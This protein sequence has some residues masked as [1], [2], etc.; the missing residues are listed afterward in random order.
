MPDRSGLSGAPKDDWTTIGGAPR[1]THAFPVVSPAPRRAA[2]LLP[3]ER[4]RADPARPASRSAACRRR[5]A[6]HRFA[7]GH[8]RRLRVALPS[9]P[10][11][12]GGLAG[13]RS[14]TRRR[15]RA[16]WPR[17]GPLSVQRTERLA[18]F[19]GPGRRYAVQ[20]DRSSSAR[21]PLG[22]RHGQLDH[23]R[24]RTGDPDGARG[25]V[26]RSAGPALPAD[27]VRRSADAAALRESRADDRAALDPLPARGLHLRPEPTR[28]G[29]GLRDR[30]GER[31]WG[32]RDPR[33]RGLPRL[34]DGPRPTA[35]RGRVGAQ[36]W[37]PLFA[38]RG[39][40]GHERCRPRS[41]GQRTR[42]RR[43]VRAGRARAGR[44]RRRRLVP[45][46]RGPRGVRRQVRAPHVP[47][48]G[49]RA[50]VDAARAALARRADGARRARERPPPEPRPRNA[51]HHALRRDRAFARRHAAQRRDLSRRAAARAHA[52]LGLVRG[53]QLR[54]RQRVERGELDAALARLD[55]DRRLGTGP[56][57]QRQL[58][59]PERR[60]R[61]PRRA[62]TGRGLPDGRRHLPACD[63]PGCG[64]W[65]GVRPVR[66]GRSGQRHRWSVGGRRRA[67][68]ARRV[69]RGR[70]PALL[71]VGARLRPAH[72]LRAAQRFPRVLRPDRGR[73]RSAA[74]RLAADLA[75]GADLATR[76]G[77]PA[78]RQQ[79]GAGRLP[80]P[81]RG[82]LH[83]LADGV[84]VRGARARVCGHARDPDRRPRRVPRRARQ[85]LQPP[86]AVSRDPARAAG[87]APARPDDRPARAR[88]CH[89]PRH[90][91]DR[92]QCPRAGR[93]AE[94]PQ[95]RRGRERRRGPRAALV[96]RARERP[97]GRL[98]RCA[99]PLLHGAP[100]RVHL[101]HA[102]Q[103]EPRRPGGRA[104]AGA[105][106]Q[107][108]RLRL[109]RGPRP[110]PQPGGRAPRARRALPA[111]AR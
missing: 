98:P 57:P 59:H 32:A 14:P 56:Q 78:R 74:H 60:Q 36:G 90:R 31:R 101:R 84:A 58:R 12:A 13:A 48:A 1:T 34:A 41:R 20:R 15:R 86:R 40:D 93:G 80:V 108:L 76:A 16:R 43:V 27:G 109:D 83:G 4:S 26:G 3:L 6:S 29:A 25:R 73:P 19:H 50:L 17:T 111:A 46:P 97:E 66:P 70:R 104:H 23:R 18:A 110:D 10:A 38:R 49:R 64:F 53:D 102:D 9:G 67:P 37:A 11:L 103:R 33:R 47:G 65:A 61:D 95:P 107:R 106:G 85:L 22:A 52:V 68:L 55:P 7:R 79:R 81:R 2:R 88:P 44:G 45:R 89:Q 5:L 63:R 54:L 8:D 35:P 28:P 30:D 21:A 75:P 96:V 105:E 87:R 72:A 24:W 82:Q 99:V 51:G 100:R 39:P 77:L 91:S 94:E 71:P 62:P 42:A 92:H 69:A